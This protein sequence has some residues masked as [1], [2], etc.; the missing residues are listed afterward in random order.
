MSTK[1]AV[2]IGASG[3]T[4]GLLVKRLIDSPIY[5]KIIIVARKPFE[6][7]SPKIE[8]Q[9]IDFQYETDYLSA[10]VGDDIFCCIGTT[11]RKAGSIEAFRKV[12]VDIPLMAAKSAKTNGSKTF[13]V[14]SSI[15]TSAKTKNYYLKAKYDMESG[16]IGCN[17]EKTGILRPSMIL[18]KRAEFR[19]GEG[20]GRILFAPISRLFTGNLRKYRP[21][22]ADAIAS[23]MLN[24]ANGTYPQTIFESD[25]IQRIADER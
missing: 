3:L 11:L 10:V 2:V 7:L 19:F 24:I 12:D 20:L 15:G 25:E 18:G 5:S 14:V 22:Q 6:N 8:T 23:A 1:T 17:F 21:I 9:L 16:V 4:G 13:I